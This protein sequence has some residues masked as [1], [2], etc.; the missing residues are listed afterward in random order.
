MNILISFENGFREILS[1]KFRSGLSM[2]GIVLGV[3]SLIAMMA[4]TSGIERG[5]RV[6]MEQMGGLELVRVVDQE[7]SNENLEFWNLSPGRTLEDARAIRE[8][9]S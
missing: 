9:S 1:H 8:S 3:S 6:F 5:S 4:I 7:I 2:L